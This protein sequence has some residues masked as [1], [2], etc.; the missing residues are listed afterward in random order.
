MLVFTG[1]I[2]LCVGGLAAY[3]GRLGCLGMTTN[4]EIRGKY[5]ENGNIYDMGPKV[6]CQA[7]CFGGTSRVLFKERS[8]E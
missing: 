8:K 2:T 3:H 4:E 1:L 7:L 6:N 5:E